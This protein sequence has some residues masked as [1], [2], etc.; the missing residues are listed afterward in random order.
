M[1]L[2]LN[3][4]DISLIFQ[5]IFLCLMFH[6]CL[7]FYLNWIENWVQKN[8]CYL[9]YTPIIMIVWCVNDFGRHCYDLYVFWLLQIE[10]TRFHLNLNLEFR[11]LFLLFC[12]KSI[13][14]D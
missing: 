5:T 6:L 11:I 10:N 12:F 9:K 8:D 13:V 3:V 4:N 2:A 14:F 7:Y 1:I